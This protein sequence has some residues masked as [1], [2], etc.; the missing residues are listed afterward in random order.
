[1]LTDVRLAGSPLGFTFAFA[2]CAFFM[3]YI[4]LGHRIAADGARTG[5]D[6]LGAAMLVASVIALPLGIRDALPAFISPSLLTAAVG[7]GICSSVI[8]FVCDQLAMARLSRA[9]FSRRLA[10]LPAMVTVIAILV[11]RQVPTLAEIG[12]V[13]LVVGGVL[14]R[15]AM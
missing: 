13:L 14:L 2:N 3:L 8:P 9:T 10:L 15:R 5:I 6:R 1:M 12:G 11:L 4:V 7:V